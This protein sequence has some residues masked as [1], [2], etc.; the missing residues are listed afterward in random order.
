MKFERYTDG[1]GREW[2]R[3]V[4]TP[5]DLLRWAGVPGG[6]WRDAE[7]PKPTAATAMVEKLLSGE[8]VL[9][10]LSSQAGCGK[11]TACAHALTKQSGLW[12]HAP[13][14]AKPDFSEPDEYGVRRESLDDRMRNA[15]LLVL[16]DVGIEHSPGGYAAARITDVL[17]IR[18]ASRRPSIVTTNLTAEEFREKYG[19]RLASRLNGDALG[20]Q[21]I[22]G[23]DLRLVRNPT[24]PNERGER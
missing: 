2:V 10:V 11:S 24:P 23:P 15:G 20:W 12:V 6:F 3:R 7:K 21:H 19:Q 8:G 1:Q 22:A 5:Q 17:E 4:V 13:D 18:E 9:L 16:D 14:L